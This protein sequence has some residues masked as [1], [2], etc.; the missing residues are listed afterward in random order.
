[1][2]GG[3]A[4]RRRPFS[5]RRAVLVTLGAGWFGYG[6]LGILLNP[7]QGTTQLLGDITRWVPMTVLGWV[8]V[9]AGL[10]SVAAGATVSCPR[11][12][13]AGYAALSAVAGLW[14]AAFTIAIPDSPTASGS[15]CIWVSIALA[16]VW[17]AGMDDPAPAHMRKARIWI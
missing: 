6:W 10:V 9:V 12:Q 3:A 15:A 7:R 16:V 4:A 2:R 1:M 14:A 13:A 17:V 11:I 8:W 5:R